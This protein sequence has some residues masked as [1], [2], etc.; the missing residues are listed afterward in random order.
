MRIYISGAITGHEDTAEERFRTASMLLKAAYSDAEIVNPWRIGQKIAYTAK[1]T[2]EEFMHISFA[3]M[4]ICDSVYFIPG[5]GV[6]DGCQKER[7]YAEE[8][9]MVIL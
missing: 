9:G 1:P 3:L 6:S 8:K 2:H 7:K 5:W 4:D